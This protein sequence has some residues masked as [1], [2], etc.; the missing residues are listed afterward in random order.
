MP[1]L[2]LVHEEEEEEEEDD[3]EDT[4]LEPSDETNSL[5]YSYETFAG[6]V[7]RIF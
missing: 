5:Y 2:A 6:L 4:P 3:L 1:E 7:S